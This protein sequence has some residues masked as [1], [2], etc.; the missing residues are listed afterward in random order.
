M[1]L[2]QVPC[3]P[4]FLYVCVAVFFCFGCQYLFVVFQ[5]WHRDM[6]TV[7][8]KHVYVCI[9]VCLSTSIGIACDTSS[10]YW[11]ETVPQGAAFIRVFAYVCVDVRS[12]TYILAPC[13]HVRNN[14]Y[15]CMWLSARTLMLKKKQSACPGLHEKKRKTYYLCILIN[16]VCNKHI[17]VCIV[18]CNKHTYILSALSTQ[19][20]T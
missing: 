14:F 20:N 16:V 7:L 10:G 17:N 19:M 8:W 18:A 13:T 15:V 6:H 1:D 4:W 11:R 9:C 3:W 2:R 12:C 5:E